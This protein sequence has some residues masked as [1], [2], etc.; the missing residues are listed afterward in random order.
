MTAAPTNGLIGASVHRVEDVGLL[1]G[2]DRFCDDIAEPGALHVH[3]VRSSMA[4]A[5]IS[6]IDIDDAVV[7]P[8]VIGV[9]DAEA[10]GL[11][12][13]LF[14]AFATMLP[15]VHRPAMA[16]ATVRFV[17]EIIVAV[18]ADSR[19]HAVDAGELVVVDYEPLPTI[20]DP[21]QAATETSVLLFPEL[22][23]NVIVDVP[24]EVGER[25]AAEVSVTTRVLNQ[26]LA[27]APMEGNVILAIPHDDGTIT[28]YASA[29]MPHLLRDLTAGFIGMDAADLQMVCPAVGG[30][31]GGK[32]PAEV[33][34]T[35][36][37]ALARSLGRPLRWAQTR[38]ENLQTMHG[39]GHRFDVTLEATR[40][41]RLT[42]LKVE[43][44]SDLGAYP[45]VAIGMIMTTR[46]L[47]HGQYRIPY[48]SFHIKCVATNTAPMGPHRGAGRPEATAML[49]P[50][51]TCWRPS[52]RSIR[53]S[54]DAATKSNPT[55]SR[56]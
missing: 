38:S 50:R 2:R 48:T 10:V 36:V 5:R 41:G 35:I 25:T 14:P 6:A 46:Q 53:L 51:W 21:E 8:G 26:R 45:G 34:Y 24:F 55:T 16:G 47:C 3:F 56:T 13:I 37:V 31:F 22:G 1:T 49:E 11:G 42:A 23:T 43:A 9:Y 15:D 12:Q 29:Q 18:V 32:I 27:V 30:G 52:S 17:G 33:E 40:D 20:V 19:A 44:L 54:C 4:H 7:A 39:R 28:A